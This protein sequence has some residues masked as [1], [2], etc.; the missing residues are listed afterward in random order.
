LLYDWPQ[1]VL[2]SPV[3]QAGSL[4]TREGDGCDGL[5]VGIVEG[6]YDLHA[7][8]VEGRPQLNVV[9]RELARVDVGGAGML[10]RG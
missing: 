10:G 3:A 1:L 8:Q 7:W 6:V 2:D 4:L 9:V 5:A